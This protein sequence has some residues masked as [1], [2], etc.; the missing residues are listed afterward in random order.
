[1]KLKILVIGTIFILLTNIASASSPYGSIDVYYNDKLL[2]GKEIAKP[3][4][5]IEEPFKVRFDFTVYQRCYVSAMISEIGDGNFIVVDGP[6]KKTNVYCG[7]IFDS[8]II[9]KIKLNK[10]ISNETKKF[11]E[12]R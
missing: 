7:K 6:T 12:R 11:F 8:K 2:P 3:V 4:L 10:N 9:N 5:K 1:M